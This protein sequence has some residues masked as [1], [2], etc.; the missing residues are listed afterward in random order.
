M[1]RTTIMLPEDLKI[2]ALNR[3]NRLG[4]SLGGFIRESIERALK[5][6]GG[7]PIDDD[8]FFSDTVVFEAKTPADLAKNH[9]E[10]LYG[11]GM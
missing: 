11:D 9:D 8:P 6:K 7:N 1:K 3:A 5:P 4:L 2:R 10:Y